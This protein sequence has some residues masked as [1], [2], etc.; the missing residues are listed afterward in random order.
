MTTP[1]HHKSE[2]AAAAVLQ[3]SGEV[4]DIS[5]KYLTCCHTQM[6][7]SLPAEIDAHLDL[8]SMPFVPTKLKGHFDLQLEQLYRGSIIIDQGFINQGE[9]ALERIALFGLI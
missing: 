4:K 7:Q 9:K 8:Q 2:R 1:A 5:Q 6:C 3:L